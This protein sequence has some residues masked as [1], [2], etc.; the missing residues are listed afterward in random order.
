MSDDF[1]SEMDD[2]AFVAASYRAIL[3]RE[4]DAWASENL[5]RELAAGRL[6]RSALLREI[7]A[8]T[9]RW[10]KTTNAIFGKGSLPNLLELFPAQYAIAARTEGRGDSKVYVVR[11][12]EDFDW[13]ETHIIDDGYYET[14]GEWILT[15][16][17][18][19][20]VI[21]EQIKDIG[22]KS[23]LELG[24][25]SG[26]V[27][28]ELGRAGWEVSGVEVS[29]LAL[30]FTPAIIRKRIFFGDLL[31]VPR[32]KTYD[33]VMALDL[34]EHLNPNK[35]HLY[36]AECAQRLNSS[37]AL[38]V[39]SPMFGPDR[40]FGEIWSVYLE[41]W[42][43]DDL[44]RLLEVDDRG[45]PSGGHLIWARPEWWERM[46]RD[47]GLIRDE[48]AERLLHAKYADFFDKAPARKSLFV[49][50]KS[51]AGKDYI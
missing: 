9:E 33:I 19:F 1:S 5:P 31:S 14:L 10:T 28:A 4:P 29:H 18:S 39:N 15:P 23:V 47:H 17:P 12:P 20:S 27:L 42:R 34:F 30:A 45:W 49:L 13:L 40:I 8:S 3:G 24:C 21:A 7:A 32:G 37:G 22:G 6:S 48:D 36:I 25:S 2:H 35:L 16:D 44:F 43:R 26:Q 41:G 11:Q 51:P 38:Y 46:F 50:R